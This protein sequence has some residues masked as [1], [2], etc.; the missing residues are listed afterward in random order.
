MALRSLARRHL[1]SDAEIAALDAELDR[2]TAEAAP[3]LRAMVGVGPEIAGALLVT[4]GG[5]P[6]RLASESSFAHLCGTAPIEASSGKTK[7]YRLNRG[8][9]RQ[10]NSALYRIVVVR[11][12]HDQ[13]T[14]EYMER[15][16][17][18]GKSKAEII[19][20][21][22]RYVAREVFAVLAGTKRVAV[23]VADC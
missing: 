19:R 11:L 16:T 10:A 1:G 2:L 22:K 12:R 21:L 4:A 17:K 23:P 3:K 20:C 6:E 9:D 5:N 14:K 7:R 13:R 8:G 18:E 15:R